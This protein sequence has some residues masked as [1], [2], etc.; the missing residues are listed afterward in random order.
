MLQLSMEFIWI[1]CAMEGSGGGGGD[2]NSDCALGLARRWATYLC[3][4]QP[5]RSGLP[6]TRERAR[7]HCAHRGWVCHPPTRP[8]ASLSGLRL[9]LDFMA[10]WLII[11]A[12]CI[13]VVVGWC[14][15]VATYMP[16]VTWRKQTM[17]WKPWTCRYCNYTHTLFSPH[18]LR[19]RYTI[20]EHVE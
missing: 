5:C 17:H 7:A 15:L 20:H 6:I 19:I 8:S 18:T 12:L 4:S 1:C 11:K 3:R 10:A 2:C 9:I 13:P 14:D 16:A